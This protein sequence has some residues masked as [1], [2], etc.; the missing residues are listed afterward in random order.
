MT[1]EYIKGA[2]QANSTLP[3][4]DVGAEVRSQKNRGSKG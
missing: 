2:G 1:R 3:T 4:E